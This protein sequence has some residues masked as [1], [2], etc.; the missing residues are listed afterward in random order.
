MLLDFDLTN[1]Y[2]C[3][4]VVMAMSVSVKEKKNKVSDYSVFRKTKFIFLATTH[5]K[6]IVSGSIKKGVGMLHQIKRLGILTN[7]V[8]WVL[9]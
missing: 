4:I 9:F 5:R 8:R 3:V 1:I 6:L 7:G 2:Y